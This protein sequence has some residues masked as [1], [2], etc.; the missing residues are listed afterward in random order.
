MLRVYGSSPNGLVCA[1]C[2]ANMCFPVSA[3]W[4]LCGAAHGRQKS[5]VAG[6]IGFFDN[7]IKT[8][9]LLALGG[10]LPPRARGRAGGR[11]ADARGPDPDPYADG[12]P[13]PGLSVK[14]HSA[15]ATDS[16]SSER[17][18]SW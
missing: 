16:F 13:I 11:G 2:A 1:F 10:A 17:K 3:R 18:A 8:S 15:R 4:R 7:E 14:T 5:V 12:D 6:G 9:R